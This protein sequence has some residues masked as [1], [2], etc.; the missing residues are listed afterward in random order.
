MPPMG[1]PVIPPEDI[2]NREDQQ[3]QTHNVKGVMNEILK[4]NV[5]STEVTQ[6]S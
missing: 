3:S 6:G 2:L 4:E 1:K 5:L